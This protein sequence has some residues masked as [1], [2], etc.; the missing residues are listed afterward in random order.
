MWQTGMQL[1]VSIIAVFKIVGTAIIPLLFGLLWLKN[2]KQLFLTHFYTDS[3]DYLIECVL[4]IITEV[5]I[6]LSKQYY[7][8]VIFQGV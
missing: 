7:Q 3:L 4:L 2:F 8:I 1:E 6:P 5:P